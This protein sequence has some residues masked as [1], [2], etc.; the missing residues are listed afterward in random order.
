MRSIQLLAVIMLSFIAA[1]CSDI[2]ESSYADIDEARR[3]Q[4]FERGWLPDILPPSTKLITTRND[5]D[6]KL[7]DGQF[8]I[9]PKEFFMFQAQ[10][11]ECTK[12]RKNVDELLDYAKRGYRPFCFSSDDSTWRFYINRETGHCKYQMKP[13]LKS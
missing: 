6:L 13:N 3:E 5:L 1:S 2:V 11:K 10:T 8:T 9:D 12:S 4:V 7:S